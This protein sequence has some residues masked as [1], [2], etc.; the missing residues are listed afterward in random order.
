MPTSRGDRGRP[1][2]MPVP[3]CVCAPLG[4]ICEPIP[5]G[6]PSD[7]ALWWWGACGEL[8]GNL[9]VGVAPFSVVV[10]LERGVAGNLPEFEN[11]AGADA[12][13]EGSGELECELKYW[14]GGI[15]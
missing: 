4:S 11:V 2:L 7:I 14:P 15:S 13:V 6:M 12:G 3:P 1:E 9:P 5:P 10:G 8:A